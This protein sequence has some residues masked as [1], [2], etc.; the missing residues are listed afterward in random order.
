[1]T[2]DMVRKDGD[3]WAGSMTALLRPRG[4]AVVGASQGPARGNSIIKNLRQT[5]YAGTVFA[6]NPRYQ[7]VQGAPCVAS[8]R[9]LPSD[10]DCIVS[11]VNADA[12]CQVLTDAMD[13]GV[14]AAVVL[15][16]GFGE[17]G[18]GIERGHRLQEL[19]QAGM[20]ICGP[21]CYGVL[22]LLDGVAT[23]SG[24]IPTPA[25]AGKVALVSQ[26]G[27]LASNI[28]QPMM[29]D[30]RLGFSYIISCG[31]QIGVG[32]ED[33]LEYIV[34]ESRTQV[35]AV[36]VESLR[37]PQKL[38][39]VSASA[40]RKGVSLL[41]LQ[42]GRS[43]AGGMMIRSHTGALVENSEVM[44]AFLRR[45]GIVQVEEYDE[46][47][48][49]I[50][51]M[52][53]APAGCRVGKSVV[54]IAGSGGN[55]TVAADT[56]EKIGLPLAEIDEPSERRLTAVMPAFGNVNNPIDGTGA[57][58]DDETMLPRLM[59][60]VLS[61]PGDPVIAINVSAK[62][63]Q[64]QRT[65]RFAETIAHISRKSERCIVGYQ[66]SHLGGDFDTALVD[67]LHEGA[68]PLLLGTQNAM[69]ALRY[70]YL[71]N[72]LRANFAG[73]LLARRPAPSALS[74]P[75]TI[76]QGFL[77]QREM[78]L[79][80][81]IPIVDARLATTQQEAIGAWRALG[82][83]VALKVEAPGLLHKTEI[84][85][86]FL[87]CNNEVTTA[88]AFAMA[89]SNASR[90]G[91][92]QC[93]TLLQPM[94]RGVCEC[95]VG[96]LQ[97]DLFGP[98]VTMGI[99]GIYVE[100]FSDVVTETAPLSR[101]KALDMIARMKGS[102]LLRGARGKPPAD[103]EALADL[104]VDLGEFATQNIGRFKALDLNPVIVMAKGEGV[105]VVDIAFET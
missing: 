17:G 69:R 94:T 34:E 84:G 5:G 35:V 77:A 70:L 36:I 82:G 11:A 50:E 102:M 60:A 51:L 95:F 56:L 63:G 45:C 90:A 65:R 52:A 9:D 100:I 74:G 57:I 87:D 38:M 59:D 79:S 71:R 85:G 49:T 81:K 91:Y 78:L 6:V 44:A 31:N 92:A 4:V 41:F 73:S 3:A 86:V 25:L 47:I 101:T 80:A 64:G 55:A 1:M 103:I 29:G 40:H 15:A 105:R 76:P 14:R 48:E 12:S 32:I 97:D 10:V 19:A 104:L 22:N 58:Y 66:Y 23:Y 21:N 54:V 98:V 72:Q 68:V 2:S 33:Y 13:H 28:L 27:G 67:A 53:H 99:G 24:A 16:A 26:S 96:I 43:K 62:R 7:E 89:M 46:F 93:S 20:A 75:S 18:K 8:V 61:I 83:N 30:R 88:D 37:N 42:T 39:S